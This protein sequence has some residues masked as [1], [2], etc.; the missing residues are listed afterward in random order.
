M[1]STF[2]IICLLSA[3]GSFLLGTPGAKAQA[4]ALAPPADTIK[5]NHLDL[6]GPITWPTP[7]SELRS[8]GGFP[9]ARYWQNRADYQIKAT[10]AEL[11]TDTTVTGEVSILYTNNSPDKLDY[12][13]L[14]MDQNLFKP[15]SRGAATTPVS[16]D[17]FDVRGFSPG[18]YHI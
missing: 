2:K 16:G 7:G 13:W 8:P 4:P 6:F 18:G 11:P 1:R 5:Y 15:G 12:L 3:A 9:G 17:R 10:L 14:Q